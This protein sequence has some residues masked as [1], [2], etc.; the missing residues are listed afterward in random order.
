MEI[1]NHRGKKTRIEP[2]PSPPP[3]HVI[4]VMAVDSACVVGN[5][6]CTPLRGSY[7][8][9]RAWESE[10]RWQ[11]PSPYLGLYP[12]PSPSNTAMPCRTTHAS[13][14]LQARIDQRDYREGWPLLTVE[15]EVTWDSK[16]T[17]ER[18]PSLICFAE[19][20]VQVQEIFV[21]PWLL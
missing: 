4:L 3:T 10:Q 18:G 2:L 14:L 8:K 7:I 5:N 9:T 11:L 1:L 6:S 13:S 12:P 19:L 16:S 21:L 20:V 15:I 17:N